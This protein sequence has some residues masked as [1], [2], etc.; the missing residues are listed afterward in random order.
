MPR[1]K[2][3]DSFSRLHLH[4]VPGYALAFS[5]VAVEGNKDSHNEPSYQ[6]IC[7]LTFSLCISNIN[8]FAIDTLMNCR[9]KFGT[10]KTYK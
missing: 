3:R 5:L 8:L 2:F 10:E 9:L 1:L 7:C 4:K 6:D